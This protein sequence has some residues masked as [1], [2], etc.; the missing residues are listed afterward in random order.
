MG[1][2]NEVISCKGFE[3]TKERSTSNFEF[4][5]SVVH[6]HTRRVR[7]HGRRLTR[8]RDCGGASLSHPVATAPDQDL[9]GYEPRQSI[10]CG[11][12]VTV[13]N[14]NDPALFLFGFPSIR[15]V[16]R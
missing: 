11:T 8:W 7:N 14:T 16:Y 1:K 9:R 12:Y 13:S 10:W 4:S 3:T 15:L 6:M 2:F 5:V